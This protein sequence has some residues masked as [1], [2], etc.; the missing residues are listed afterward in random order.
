MLETS[1]AQ[2]H[3]LETC[4]PD[5]AGPQLSAEQRA[6]CRRF[7]ANVERCLRRGR[8]LGFTDEDCG[9]V[10]DAFQGCGLDHWVER[11]LGEWGADPEDPADR[12]AAC[13][14]FEERLTELL[15]R[16]RTA[17]AEDRGRELAAGIGR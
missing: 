14:H 11:Y 16:L 6:A 5:S 4:N 17:F 9:L 15:S 12:R 13:D 3:T 1:Q 2:E 7:D 10:R 8:E